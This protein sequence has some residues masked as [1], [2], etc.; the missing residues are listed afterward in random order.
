MVQSSSSSKSQSKSTHTS[1]KVGHPS[2]KPNAVSM[3]KAKKTKQQSIKNNVR[4][5][6]YSFSVGLLRI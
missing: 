6:N 5:G 3:A 1:F 2:K 4:T